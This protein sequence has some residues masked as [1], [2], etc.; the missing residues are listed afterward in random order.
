MA[1]IATYGL[2][3]HEVW[4]LDS[5]PCT[6]K[7]DRWLIS[8]ATCSADGS[9]SKTKTG[10]PYALSLPDRGLDRCRLNDRRNGH[11]NGHRMLSEHR[12]RYPI[13]TA[14]RD[15]GAVQLMNNEELGRV[16]THWMNTTGSPDR[17][18]SEHLSGYHQPRQLPGQRKPKGKRERCKSH[19]L[20]LAW[21]LRAR[22]TT[23]WA[24]S[25]KA[26][27]MG[28]SEAG[29]AG[30]YLVE[31]RAEH[32]RQGLLPFIAQDERRNDTQ[33]VITPEILALEQQLAELHGQATISRPGGLKPDGLHLWVNWSKPTERCHCRGGVPGIEARYNCTTPSSM[34][35]PAPHGDW[36]TT[37]EFSRSPLF[38]AG[39][40]RPG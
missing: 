34:V 17:E 29:H 18:L 35:N 13:K 5:L 25:L 30:R 3:K 9:E 12:R 7:D 21:G 1:M 20:R 6:D 38:R 40:P 31:E 10:H 22:E 26:K 2:R 4:H 8:V 32:R 36:R 19:D 23:A 14:E 33:A 39:K 11:R 24:T 37:C 15:D 27:A 16:L 28:H